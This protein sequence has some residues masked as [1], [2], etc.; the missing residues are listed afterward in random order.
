MLLTN[1]FLILDLVLI[2]T[3]IKSCTN[4]LHPLNFFS[5]VIQKNYNKT[6]FVGFEPRISQ[7]ILLLNQVNQ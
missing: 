7:K 3:V 4:Q 5:P 6:A 1:S 2:P